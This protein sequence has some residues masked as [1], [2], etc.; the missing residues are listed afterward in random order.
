MTP[1]LWSA[2]VGLFM[3]YV[4]EFVKAFLPSKRWVGFSLALGASV[5]VGGVSNWLGGRLIADEV[6]ASIGG[7]LIAS[8]SVYNY[9]F[10]SAGQDERIQKLLG[11]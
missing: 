1:Q 2:L 6:L 11:K 8:Q 9:W 10:K 5:V 7:A 4:V 3:P